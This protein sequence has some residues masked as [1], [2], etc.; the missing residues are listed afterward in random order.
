MGRPQDIFPFLV[1]MRPALTL[2]LLTF[3]LF[4]LRYSQFTS[5]LSLNNTQVKLFMGLVLVMMLGV[6]F[7]Y[8]RRY[9]F[10]VIVTKY[11]SVILYFLIF[12]A[13][14]NNTYKLKKILFI[15]CLGTTIYSLY[16]LTTGY[17]ARS[18]LMAGEMFDPNDLGFFLLS[19]IPYNFLFLSKENR[20]Y[21]KIISL[22]NVVIGTMVILMTG[23]R[24]SFIALAVVVMILLLTKT[25][26]IKAS[27]KIIVVILCVTAISYKI[28]DI[29]FS[30]FATILNIKEDYNITHEWGRL[31]IWKRGLHLIIA[32]PI[33]GVGVGCFDMALGQDREERGKIPKWQTA[34]NSLVQ[35]GSETGVVGLILFALMSIKA[36]GI[37]KRVKRKAQSEE[38]VKIGEMARAGFVGHF[39][40]AMFLSQAYS[41]YWAFYIVFSAVLYQ[42]MEQ[43]RESNLQSSGT[44]TGFADQINGKR[45]R[46]EE[47]IVTHYTSWQPR[48]QETQ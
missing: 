47:L 37:F 25:R 31:E 21:K 13:L 30:R 40:I 44:S 7:A 20:N 8:Y 5:Q 11:S 36:Y 34:H 18:R 4:L 17:F 32:H 39:I 14:V 9:A 29:E 6:P 19:F 33:T 2:G 15:A 16:A 3:L 26:T 28:S 48:S 23:S 38:L 10:M 41:V 12:Y 35:V 42:F 1:P 43:E 22:F 46:R 45:P 27:Y 24:S